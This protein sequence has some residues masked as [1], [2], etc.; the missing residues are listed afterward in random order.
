MPS[1]LL[2]FQTDSVQPR[3]FEAVVSE[4]PPTAM[5]YGEAAG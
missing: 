3:E 2:V 1:A 4:V 5:T